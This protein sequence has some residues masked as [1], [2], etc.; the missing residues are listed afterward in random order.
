MKFLHV[1]FFM[2]LWPTSVPAQEKGRVPEIGIVQDFENDSLLGAS[3]YHYMVESVANCFSPRTISDRQFQEKLKRLRKLRTTVIACNIFIPGELK[4]VGPAVD[5]KAVLAYA[6]IVFRRCQEAGVKLIIWGSA[7]SRRVPD[8][9]DRRKA[10]EQFIAMAIKVSA[11]AKKYHIVLALENLNSTETNF[12]N[13]LQE[14]YEIVQQAN[15]PNFRLCADIYHMLKENEPPSVIEKT[16]KY[17]VHC[18]L[19]EREN[20]AP[21]GTHGDD[22]RGYFVELKKIGYKGRIV[23]E[24]RWTDLAAQAVPARL[25]IRKQ[26]EEIYGN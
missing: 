24:C 12:I 5:E 19:A 16:G 23:L 2:A 4:V 3:G 21:P 25:S 6:D 18:D 9:F 8:G 17:L 13:T 22:F 15:H 20:R 14:A 26:L 11:E 10:R 1:I 7:G